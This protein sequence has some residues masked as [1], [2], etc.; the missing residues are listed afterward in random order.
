MIII[1]TISTQMLDSRIGSITLRLIRITPS[2]LREGAEQIIHEGGVIVSYVRQPTISGMVRDL[3]GFDLAYPAGDLQLRHE[4]LIG[5]KA[6][7]LVV[8]SYH[9]PRIT[10]GA[11]IPA[12]GRIDLWF[13]RPSWVALGG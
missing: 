1:P 4:D 7:N 8:A 12:D 13:V 11:P 3:V 6:Q 2:E 10:E 9:G 5:D